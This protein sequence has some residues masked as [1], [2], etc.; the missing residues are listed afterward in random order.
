MKCL[1]AGKNFAKIFVKNILQKRS[2]LN[3]N[4]Q[5]FW[6]V[7]NNS[8]NAGQNEYIKTSVDLRSGLVYIK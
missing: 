5:H 2:H 3:K 6:K 1:L 4:T 7:L 8:F